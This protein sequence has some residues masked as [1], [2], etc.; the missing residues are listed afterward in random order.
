MSLKL[1]LAK[2]VWKQRWLPLRFKKSA[3]RELSRHGERPDAPFE[4]AF[5]GL[6]YRGNLRNNVDF[7]VFFYGAFEKPVL[8]FMADAF[9]LIRRR[10]PARRTFC[11]IGANVGQH[12]LF[13]ATQGARVQAFEPYPA[14]AA[15]LAR[16]VELNQL[17]DVT[18]HQVGLAE[19]DELLP[20][21]PPLDANQ[22][23]GSFQ[24]DD[25]MTA[26]NCESLPVVR[27]DDYFRSE[28]INNIALIKIDVEGFERSA[29]SGM[30]AILA[31]E[32]PVLVM[33]LSHDTEQ[34]FGSEHELLDMLPDNY[35]LLSF[36]VRRPDGSKKK[37]E[38]SRAKRSG[39][40]QLQQPVQWLGREQQDIVAC[41]GEL[42]RDLP[43]QN[44]HKIKRA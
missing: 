2:A 22:G 44:R 10:N 25:A 27:A 23:A 35:T 21:Q 4:R 13:M 30:Q 34:A 28:E 19:N 5:Y 7:S 6:T 36:D 1:K 33:E 20:F 39:R 8:H 16:H 38:E 37:R 41:P 11:D 29:L 3:Y 24:L 17:G 12:S 18:L 9:D 43:R 32:R 42:L 26:H 31:T 15:C 14:V 40:Y